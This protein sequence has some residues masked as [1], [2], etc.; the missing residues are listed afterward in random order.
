MLIT[1]DNTYET[2]TDGRGPREE[3][4]GDTGRVSQLNQ[5]QGR[6]MGQDGAANGGRGT[7]ENAGQVETRPFTQEDLREPI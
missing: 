1:R 7:S 3:D 4:T 5:G 2:S 6:G